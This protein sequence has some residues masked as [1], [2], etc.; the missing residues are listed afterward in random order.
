MD[1]VATKVDAALTDKEGTKA[2]VNKALGGS[3]GAA[4]PAATPEAATQ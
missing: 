3:G 4:P 1:T 2:Q